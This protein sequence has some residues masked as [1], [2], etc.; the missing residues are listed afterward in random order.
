LDRRPAGVLSPRPRALRRLR[1]LFK[2]RLEKK[3]L[4]LFARVP[5]KVWQQEWVVHCVPWG[6]NEH[7]VLD[8]LARYVFRIAITERRILAMDDQSVTFQY[9]DRKADRQRTCRLDGTEFVRRYLQHVLPKGF[10]KVR[11]YGLWNPRRARPDGAGPADVATATPARPQPRA[12]QAATALQTLPPC[13]PELRRRTG[14]CRRDSPRTLPRTV[15]A[16]RDCFPTTLIRVPQRSLPKRTG[17]CHAP[18][19]PAAPLWPR[20]SPCASGQRRHH[21]ALLRS[22]GP[23]T[24]ATA[25]AVQS[26]GVFTA[27]YRPENP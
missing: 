1:E 22:T 24:P 27:E 2:Q 13:L 10:H 5:A 18:T 9:K 16:S 26:N 6:Q 20:K 17:F 23:P 19:S 25:P 4:E 21:G 14:P 15:A 8:Y 11:Y 3:H 7:G 12:G